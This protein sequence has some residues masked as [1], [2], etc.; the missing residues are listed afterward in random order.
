MREVHPAELAALE[1]DNTNRKSVKL[2]KI[3]ELLNMSISESKNE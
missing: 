2:P 3:E 1:K